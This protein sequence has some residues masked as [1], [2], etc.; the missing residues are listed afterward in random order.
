MVKDKTRGPQTRP[1]VR[2]DG[3][4][5]RF[6]LLGAGL[7]APFHAKA[8]QATPGCEVAGITDLN[9]ELAGKRAGEFDC[10]AF[11]TYDQMLA[12]RG[13]DVIN[14]LLP[15][16]LHCQ[17]TLQ[18]AA[19]GKHVLVEKPPAMKLSELD[20]MISACS[21]AGVK[22][23]VVLNVR[24]RKAIQAIRTAIGQGRFGR[25]LAGDAHMKWWRGNDYY[26]MAAWR[27]SQR[28]GSGVTVA[29]AFHYLDLL[30]YLMGRPA[31]V[32]AKMNNIA[33]PGVK[34]EDTT[35]A[36][37][38]YQSG[39]VGVVSASTALWPGTDIRIEING[40]NG[41]AIMT[42]ERLS[43]WKFRDERP[44]DEQLRQLGSSAKATGAGGAADFDFAE[45]QT[46]I[47]GMARAV[48]ENV[49]PLITAPSARVTVEMMLA[50][51]QSAKTGQAVRLPLADDDDSIWQ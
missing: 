47:A 9:A 21:Q 46:V 41:T 29:Q 31:S 38:E 17:P 37:I 40:E 19:A 12:D 35:R 5:I 16:H 45:H 3:D 20:Q 33:H 44:E 6:G 32:Q 15:N 22:L 25:L 43:T 14:V 2:R 36:F 13:I 27:S 30:Q 1:D 39:A 42:G 18:A 26:G 49:D 11:A 8:I 4:P 34:L 50:L 24:C 7:I 48:R 23:G 51:Y 28:A 10:K